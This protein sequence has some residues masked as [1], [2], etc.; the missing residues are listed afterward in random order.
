MNLLRLSLCFPPLTFSFPT[1]FLIYFFVCLGSRSC[2]CSCPSFFFSLS[3]SVFPL[4]FS[5]LIVICHP[6]PSSVRLSRPTDFLAQTSM[7]PILFLLLLF[8]PFLVI[9]TGFPLS[10]PLSRIFPS[11]AHSSPH[12]SSSCLS[13][14]DPWFFL[15]MLLCPPLLSLPYVGNMQRCPQCPSQWRPN[16]CP[17]LLKMVS[18]IPLMRMLV[19]WGQCGEEGNWCLSII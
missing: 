4:S 9:S 5:C 7:D 11:P 3:G 2:F 19:C 12:L 10:F 17:Y 6:F 15:V 1:T 18:G 13:F 8:H 14:Y 16:I